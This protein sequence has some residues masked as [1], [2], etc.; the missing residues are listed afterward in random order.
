MNVSDLTTFLAFSH[1][2]TLLDKAIE[3]LNSFLEDSENC[4][5]Y[6]YDEKG[7]IFK[8]KGKIKPFLMEITK[9]YQN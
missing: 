5:L 4:T 3:I 7:N 9:N 8:P 6:L 2:A 1:D